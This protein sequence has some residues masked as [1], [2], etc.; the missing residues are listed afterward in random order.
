[1][2][3]KKCASSRQCTE[4]KV[5]ESDGKSALITIRIAPALTVFPR[6]FFHGWLPIR[7]T[8]ENSHRKEIWKEW[9]GN[10]RNR[11]PFCSQRQI[12][13]QERCR[14]VREALEVLYCHWR[15]LCSW[16]IKPNF[17]KNCCF[18]GY[19][20][21]FSADVLIICFNRIIWVSKPVYQEDI[22]IPWWN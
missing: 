12:V 6:F 21:D 18:L 10:R 22:A 1:M 9:R 13:L 15:K 7:K 16:I 19:S 2:K 4:L 17:A 20:M 14:N 11:G 3:K 8:Q 5:D